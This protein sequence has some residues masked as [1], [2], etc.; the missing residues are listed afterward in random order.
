MN[1]NIERIERFLLRL[2][3]CFIF[4]NQVLLVRRLVR[5]STGMLFH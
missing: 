5:R 4:A 2:V 1:E 3:A